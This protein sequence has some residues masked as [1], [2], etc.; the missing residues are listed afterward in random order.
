MLVDGDILSVVTFQTV[1]VWVSVPNVIP[2]QEDIDVE[3]DNVI[4]LKET[5]KP[6]PL[7]GPVHMPP[8]PG[9]PR[10]LESP[11]PS[12]GLLGSSL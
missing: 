11:S 12:S 1:C 6:N 9:S 8:P 7:Q 2:Q 5:L 4:I 3:G 10:H